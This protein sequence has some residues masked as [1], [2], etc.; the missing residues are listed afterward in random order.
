LDVAGLVAQAYT[1][2]E[3]A[4]RLLISERT[5]DKHVQ[6]ILNRLGLRSRTQAATWAVQHGIAAVSA[7]S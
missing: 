2:R 5:V 1:N 4:E 3:I 7:E 6:N